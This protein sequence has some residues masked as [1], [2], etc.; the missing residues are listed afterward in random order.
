MDL[1]RALGAAEQ[2]EEGLLG[3][4][5]QAA[6]DELTGRLRPGVTPED[7]REALTVAAAWM[8]LGGLA[9]SRQGEGSV[10]AWTL[11]EWSV[12][13]RAAADGQAD[14]CRAQAE[15]LMAPYLTDGDFAFLG[16]RG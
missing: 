2:E 9:V 5:C 16:V 12:K 3:K 4:L 15:R 7:C 8:A 14:A 10:T 11:G 13:E 6:L 1:A